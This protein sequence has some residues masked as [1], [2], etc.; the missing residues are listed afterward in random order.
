[1][2]TKHLIYFCN[3]I[4]FLAGLYGAIELFSLLHIAYKSGKNDAKNIYDAQFEWYSLAR[5]FIALG[6]IFICLLLWLLANNF[7]K[8]KVFVRE[9]EQL[10]FL[11]GIAISSFGLLSNIVIWLM[12][13]PLSSIASNLLILI[14]CCFVFISIMFRIGIRLQEEQELTI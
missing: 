4:I 10:F 12:P 11:F 5:T 9:N 14:G 13:T 6:I 1:M 7:R 2:K 8:E 3:F